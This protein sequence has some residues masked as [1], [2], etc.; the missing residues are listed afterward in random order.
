M[1]ETDDLTTDDKVE[2]LMQQASALR[3]YGVVILGDGRDGTM[4][5]GFVMLS[6][7]SDGNGDFKQGL[8]NLL[9]EKLALLTSPGVDHE[10]RSRSQ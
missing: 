6:N 1:A 7:V 10:V 9:T 8:I 5:G 2:M 4:Q 3:L